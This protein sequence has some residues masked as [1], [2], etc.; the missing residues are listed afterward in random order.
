MTMDWMETIRFV[1]LDLQVATVFAVAGVDVAARALATAWGRMRSRAPSPGA[2]RV[3][4]RRLYASPRIHP[5][6][7]AADSC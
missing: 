1:G 5:A 6:V 7:L 4:T 2:L 3:S